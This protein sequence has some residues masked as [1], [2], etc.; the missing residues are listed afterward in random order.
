M[1][2]KRLVHSWLAAELADGLNKTE[3]AAAL[4]QAVGTDYG[5][6]RIGEWEKDVRGVPAK[7]RRYMIRRALGIVLQEAGIDVAKLTPLQ[8]RKIADGLS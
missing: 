5:L 1:S 2:S 6:S 4:S 8:L 7:V 3:A